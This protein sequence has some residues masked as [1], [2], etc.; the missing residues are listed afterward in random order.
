MRSLPCLLSLKPLQGGAYVDIVV[1]KIC[2][3]PLLI[4]IATLIARR[5]GPSVGGWF[6][7]LPLT[8][9][10]VLLFL[11]LEQG[12]GF[13]AI[14]AHGSLTGLFALTAF[15]L[16]YFKCARGKAWLRATLGGLLSYALTMKLVSMFSLALLP[17]LVLLVIVQQLALFVIGKAPPCPSTSHPPW[18]DLPLRMGLAVSIVLAIT[19]FATVLGPKWSGLLAPFPAFVLIMA[20]FSMAQHGS[21]AAHQF[22]QGIVT[23]IPACIAFFG[24][25]AALSA[26][27]SLWVVFSLAAGAAILVNAL[28][29]ALI[30]RRRRA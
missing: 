13:S 18:W 3:T 25:V 7:G 28:A 23:T 14:S 5:W 17:E 2:L 21:A 19:T 4:A 12:A 26:Y 20:A 29:L 16:G 9:G 15:C 8:S 30:I 22:M 1:F 24:I 11:A 10:P 6:V 27:Y